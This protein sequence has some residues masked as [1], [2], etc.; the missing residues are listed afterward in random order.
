MPDQPNLMDTH[1]PKVPL[2]SNRPTFVILG[3]LLIVII[4]LGAYYFLQ[5]EGKSR[6]NPTNGHTE[7]LRRGTPA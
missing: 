7:L 6:S 2:A 3:I 1:R 5:R 4:L